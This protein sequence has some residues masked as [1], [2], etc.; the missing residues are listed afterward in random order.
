MGI[1]KFT[2]LMMGVPVRPT[3]TRERAR[4][5]QREA[6][7]LASQQ[8]ALLE[9]QLEQQIASQEDA[10]R[11]LQRLSELARSESDLSS[12]SVPEGP[13][14]QSFSG[15]EKLAKLAELRDSGVLTDEEFERQKQIVLDAGL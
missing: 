14:T 15:L 3:T 4:K 6:N 2:A 7:R 9:Q 1:L 12:K 13:G 11:R 8:N 10:A 5:Y